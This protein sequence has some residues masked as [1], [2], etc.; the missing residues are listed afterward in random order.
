MKDHSCNCPVCGTGSVKS[1]LQR[2]NVPVLQN[3]VVPSRE[4]ATRVPRGDLDMMVCLDCGFIYN[5]SFSEDKFNYGEDYDNT[6][7]HSPYFQN[8]VS[9]LA[10]DLINQKRVVRSHVVEVGC[11]KGDFL[12]L[13]VKD[14]ENGNTGDGFDPS[15][16]GPDSVCDGRLHFRRTLYDENCASV[17]ADVVVSRH[18]IEHIRRPRSM[19]SAIRRALKNSINPRIYLETPCVE[20]ILRNKV[21]WDFFYEHCSLFTKDSLRTALEG[22]GF[23]MS[24]CR[25]VFDGQYLFTE[26]VLSG[27]GESVHRLAGDIPRLA[28]EFGVEEKKLIGGWG[29]RLRSLAAK[30]KVAIWGAGAKGSTFVNMLDPQGLYIDCVIDINPQKKGNFIPGTGHAILGYE[31]LPARQ[32]DYVVLMNPNYR[33]EI[34]GLLASC[35]INVQLFE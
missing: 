11:G 5:A 9:K 23:R 27:K 16:I 28:E 12:R 4:A 30:G 15:Y 19:L 3:L 14:P 26:A 8:Y 21:I 17:P 2:K 10:D 31:T 7:T 35:G 6:Q 34:K 24:E 1:F 20:W 13:L 25:H 22:E 18:V 29:E 33:Q 32:I